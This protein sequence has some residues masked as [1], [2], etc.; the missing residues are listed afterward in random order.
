MFFG[1]F[2]LVARYFVLDLPSENMEVGASSVV[3]LDV[4]APRPLAVSSGQRVGFFID[5][6]EEIPREHKSKIKWEFP[7]NEDPVKICTEGIRLNPGSPPAYVA[8]INGFFI[9]HG[10][11]LKVSGLYEVFADINKK[12]GNISTKA[13]VLVHGTVSQSVNI[14]SDG[15]VEV[16]GLIEDATVRAAG[17]IVAKGGIAG[18]DIGSMIAGKSIYSQFIQN[19][20]AEAS[21]DILVDGPVMNSRIICGKKLTI[22]KKGRLVGGTVRVMEGVEVERVG[23]ESALPTEIE[24]GSNPFSKIIMERAE[25]KLNKLETEK[26]TVIS[27][28]KHKAGD[29]PLMLS[30]NP[31]DIVTSLFD[32]A[33]VVRREGGSLN[34]EQMEKISEFGACIMRHIKLD[35]NI[36]EDRKKL[37]EI[38]QKEV[39][40]NNAR[41]KVSQIA[42]PGT[43]IK[44]SGATM[45]LSNEYEKVSFYYDNNKSEIG[46]S[47]L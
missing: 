1:V 24:L 8:L 15:D 38:T 23:S 47:Y 42:H 12:T 39:R 44:I 41:L 14:S 13:S 11:K 7:V 28:I 33:D 9:A 26:T 36:N 37:D 40:F 6:G 32:A 3:P 31:E 29:L 30:F 2:Y 4:L 43:I 25:E 22:R 17:N 35:Q 19:A 18:N 45:R 16:R 34:A 20:G 46:V 27:T 10:Q 5:E 21:G